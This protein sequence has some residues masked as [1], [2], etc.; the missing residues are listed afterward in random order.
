M[1]AAELEHAFGAVLENTKHVEHVWNDDV[2]AAPF[3]VQDFSA[4]EHPRNVAE[5]ALQHFDVNSEGEHVQPADL[6]L[7]P[8]MRRR[9]RIQIDAGETLQADGVRFAD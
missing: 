9:F 3:G 8:P 4:R 7:L 2:I 5:P 6:D 1:D